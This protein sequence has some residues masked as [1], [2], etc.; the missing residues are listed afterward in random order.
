MCSRRDP[1]GSGGN[2]RSLFFGQRQGRQE[3]REVAS[4]DVSAR[5]VPAHLAQCRVGVA[6]R[7]QRER[8]S[9]RRM[10]S[11]T[12]TWPSSRCSTS[13]H[14]HSSPP[15]T[16]RNHTR[17]THVAPPQRATPH[18]HRYDASPLLSILQSVGMTRTLDLSNIDEVRTHDP[19]SPS[20]RSAAASP[21]RSAHLA[22]R[23]LP[24]PATNPPLSP[25]TGQAG[26]D[27]TR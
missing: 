4:D 23:S 20:L 11:R 7:R 27:G 5:I 22:P 21:S 16:L 2:C 8:C 9:R 15:H 6:R 26:P 12:P 3:K 17:S 18:R 1:R 10:R 19:S 25:L 24:S 13:E 14:P